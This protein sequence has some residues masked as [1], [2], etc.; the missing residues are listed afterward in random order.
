MDSRVKA[1]HED[2]TFVEVAWTDG[3]RAMQGEG[4]T[5]WGNNMTDALIVEEKGTR[6]PFVRSDNMDELLGVIHANKIRV[7]DKDGKSRTLQ[8]VIS[9]FKS[10]VNVDAEFGNG[11]ERVVLR[12]H[13]T[14]IPLEKGRQKFVAPCH[15]SYQ[16]LDE[17]NPRN[18]IL[19]CTPEGMYVHA[20]GPGQ[21]K[22]LAQSG[23]GEEKNEH[24]HRVE[25][26]DRK[27]GVAAASFEETFGVEGMGMRKNAFV[28]VSIPLVQNV[29]KTP[30]WADI[31]EED[32]AGSQGVYR[33]LGSSF[34]A[35]VSADMERV[36]GK[37]KRL[38]KKMAR[39]E[40]RYK[41]GAVKKEPI[42]V[43]LLLYNTVSG[44]DISD[45]DIKLAI[46]DMENI[47]NLCEKRGKLSRLEA[48]LHDMD[49]KCMD[50]I[51]EKVFDPMSFS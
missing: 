47:Y 37:S 2:Y 35:T 39:S 27:V 43:T 41:N 9:S 44:G 30:R 51:K 22:L 12:V 25:A 26:S 45:E 4:L 20:D 8:D 24:W 49:D 32:T 7:K 34:S 21:K 42:V 31:E 50:K 13:N 6:F 48:M 23:E 36:A 46:N 5:P 11:N 19:L 14:W 18:A 3:Q 29:Q 28:V 1:I 40:K 10:L 33:S 15:Y 16:T 38:P 17:D